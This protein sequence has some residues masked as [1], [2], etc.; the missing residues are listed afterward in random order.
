M[1]WPLLGAGTAVDPSGHRVPKRSVQAQWPLQTPWRPI[2][3]R[4]DSRGLTAHLR[5]QSKAQ[6][7]DKGQTA[8]QRHAAKVGRRVRGELKQI[9]RRIVDAGL[10]PDD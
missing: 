4:K 1:R 9:E 6:A 8:A 7:V 3:R 5:G 10:M 2:D